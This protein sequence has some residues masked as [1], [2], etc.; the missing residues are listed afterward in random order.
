MKEKRTDFFQ[1]LTEWALVY[2]VFHLFGAWPIP[3]SNEPYYIGKAIHYWNPDWIV[4][5]AF[6]ES[7]DSHWTFY[8]VFG[9][10][11][12]FLSPYGMA[13]VG[14]IITWGLLAWSWR[15][16]SFALVPIRW[17]SV[18]TA[19]ALAY[20]V[21]SFH[22]AGEWIL[23]G[24]EG[25]SFAFPFV[26]FG[27]EAMVRG[28][29]HRT[30]IFLGVASAFHVLVGGWSVL[31]AAF[32]WLT[33]DASRHFSRNVKGVHAFLPWGLF[34]GGLISLFGLVPA[35]M[36]DFGSPR[37]IVREAHQIYVFER[38]YHHLVPYMMPW[39]HL[40]RF[41]LLAAVWILIC[42]SG[43]TENRKQHRFDLFVWGTLILSLVGFVAAYGLQENRT[44]AAEILRF[45]WFRLA[46]V[47]V[48]MGVAIGACRRLAPLLERLFSKKETD[49]ESTPLPALSEIVAI[50][51]LPFL[52][53]LSVDYLLFGRLFFS[54]TVRPEQGIPWAATLIFCWA[55]FRFPVWFPN[56]PGSSRLSRLAPWGLSGIYVMILIVA[57]FHS[58]KELAD[59]RTRFAYSRIEP[60]YPQAAFLWIDAC[61]WISDPEN[62]DPAAK[63]WIPYER[64]T[65]KWHARRSDI[66]VRKDIP[67]DAEGIVLW[68]QTMKDLFAYVDEEDRTRWDR[69]LTIQLW[70]K[71]PDEIERLREKYGFDY[72]LCGRY[73]ELPHLPT[74]QPVY[75][76]D[77]YRV[78]Q[79]VPTGK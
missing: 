76:N 20:Y 18:F 39:T 49:E 17:A 19:L 67:Q 58:F 75:E 73:P 64:S 34:L 57:P 4:N 68:H 2:A 14:R 3:D 51:V 41:F 12:F 16:L 45:Y 66:G 72:I 35:L 10:L 26:F 59:A 56:F 38:I 23:G 6:L 27:L 61:Q 8:V 63:F 25:K 22:M 65:F 43:K 15:R 54:W 71:T 13:V 62:T 79:V 32:V 77:Q 24:V 50:F 36:L 37:E 31:V 5:D 53:Y 28:R 30:W 1:T 11:T 42:R 9:W 74:L 21:D 55:M 60:G 48:P 47:A 70:W 29:W 44:L 69:S 7:R 52:F 46:D 40:A 78:Y 33:C